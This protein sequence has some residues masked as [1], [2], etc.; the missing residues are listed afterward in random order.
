MKK[1]LLTLFALVC[2]LCCLFGL[3]ACDNGDKPSG[4]H[5]HN[6]RWK[7]CGD[8]MHAQF[9]LN[10]GCDNPVIDVESHI[11]KDGDG[12]CDACGYSGKYISDICYHKMER[13]PAN[14]ATCTSRGNTEYYICAHCGK[15]FRDIYG[16]EEI[17]DKN[18]V[19]T[20]KIAHDMTHIPA[21]SSTCI[22]EGNVEYYTCGSCKKWYSDVNGTTEITDKAS[23]KTDKSGHATVK[24]PP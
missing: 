5:T 3:A 17:T 16:N 9:C 19:K 8:G 23:V 22:A 6:Y 10:D 15:W 18:S 1:K 7:D 20:D 24:V 21:E 2:A 14:P 13:V 11:D 12:L 4:G